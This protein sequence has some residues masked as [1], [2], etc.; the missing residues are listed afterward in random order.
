MQQ[1]KI[2]LMMVFSI[3]FITFQNSIGI[4]AKK[5]DFK[6]Q[7]AIE[8]IDSNNAKIDV[9]VIVDKNNYI[10]QDYLN[11]SLNNPKIEILKIEFKPEATQK[12]IPEFNKQML[13]FD[14][15]L[16][17]IIYV[18]K[19]A[20]IKTATDLFI[21]LY[22]NNNETVEEQ[23]IEL[24]LFNYDKNK[25]ANEDNNIS[26]NN[27]NIIKETNKPVNTKKSFWGYVNHLSKYA[28]N[29][30]LHNDSMFLRFIFVFLLGLLMSLTPCIYPM[31]PITAG[32]LQA[33]ASKSIL[34]NLL[35]SISYTVGIATTFALFG[36]SAALT[37][38][39]FGKILMHPAFV[40]F[41]V[42]LLSYFAFAMLGFY[43]I[44]IPSSMQTGPSAKVNGSLISAFAFG[45]I[46]GSVASPCL[47]PGLALLLTVVATL[48]NKL[49]GFMLLF[50][51]GLGLGIPLLIIG[52][53]SSS[54]NVL[55]RS[56]YWMVEIKKLFAFMLFGMCFY[57][58]SNIIAF[59]KLIWLIAISIL[60]S[61]IYYLKNVSLHD[62]KFWKILKNIIGISLIACSIVVFAK[63]FQETFYTKVISNHVEIWMH[64]YDKATEKAIA[65]SKK[66]F[67]DIGADYCSICKAIDSKLFNNELVQKKLQE[68]AT[69][70]VDAT[71]EASYP[72]NSLKSSYNIMGAPTILLID[73]KTK[74]LIKKWGGELYNTTPDEFINELEQ[75]N[76]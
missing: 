18:K 10:I 7:S 12:F 49:L 56:G 1:Q 45:A 43:E 23:V 19:N 9:K 46:S 72:F 76:G 61:G 3:L 71:D 32:I 75:L 38:N 67:I 53:F 68:F 17:I 42:C 30:I 48:G 14:K 74:K 66:L 28:Q 41:L 73:P 51:F 35:L 47:S 52:T 16:D 64:D 6:I 5:N 37:G 2:Y 40:I 33:Q 39:L 15:D 22:K 65:E 36:L 20:D 25:T 8:N 11:I 27:E 21:S 70:K 62:S 13:V 50:T 54:L 60:I 57:Y 34:K 44:Y 26:L 31:I 63:A 24:N 59:N 69:V 29:A 58:L 55:P 4:I